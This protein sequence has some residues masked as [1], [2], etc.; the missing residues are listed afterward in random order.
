MSQHDGNIANQSMPSARTDINNALSAIFTLQSGSSAPV[1]T[2]AN[3]FWVDTVNN[4]L[5]QRNTADSAWL[6]KYVLDGNG[7]NRLNAGNPNGT[8]TGNYEGELLY[9]TTNDLLWAYS[10][11][12]T[13]WT[14]A[15]S[16]NITTTKT[17]NYT[18][19]IADDVIL[20]NAT[21]G[22]FT[23]TLYTAINNAGRVLKIIK[24]D[25]SANT[26]TIDGNASET[27]AGLLTIVLNSQFSSVE[28]ISDGSNWQIQSNGKESLTSGNAA[29]LPEFGCRAFVNFDGTTA[30]DL[31]GTYSQSGT[32]V[33]VNATAHNHKVG[34]RIFATIG[35]GTAVTG[36]YVVTSILGPG[37]F[38]YTAGT[39]LTTSGNITLNRRA[40]RASGNVR[41]VTFGGLGDY[42]IN[43][44]TS[45]PDINYVISQSG[46]TAS[47]GTNV[48]YAAVA[49]LATSGVQVAES[50]RVQTQASG[51]GVGGNSNLAYVHVTVYR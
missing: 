38:T 45:M 31:S 49:N 44:G 16:T 18:A 30:A 8:I 6:T 7:L 40:I 33:T 28:I 47:N 15:T 46:S 43:F 20:A 35:S 21:S 25:S 48:V 42:W 5:K 24:T 14:K 50:A 26:I 4:V 51:N 9:D 17:T 37:S 1:P 39:S 19:T 34:D 29:Y 27:I 13:I 36:L 32:T 23:I 2:F 22:S 3:M 10:G 41:N 12:G 11:T